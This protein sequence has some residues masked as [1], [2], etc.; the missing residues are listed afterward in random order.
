MK[1]LKCKKCFAERTYRGGRP[2][3]FCCDAHRQSYARDAVAEMQPNEFYTP[4]H[5]IELAR[6]FMGGIDLDPASCELANET[7]GAKR[8][9]DI[10]QDGLKRPWFGNIFLNPPY[11]RFGPPFVRKAV[12]EFKSWRIEQ[13]IILLN[14]NHIATHWFNDAMQV[15]HLICLPRK[16]INYTS[17]IHITSSP[18]SASVLVGIGVDRERFIEHFGPLGRI[19]F[20]PQGGQPCT[21]SSSP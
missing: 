14:V 21:P 19:A 17:P 18:T 13:A 11:S 4:S 5:I 10:K 7:V 3:R 16:R 20:V 15:A 12:E 9:Y 1:C 2:K 8:F 6:A